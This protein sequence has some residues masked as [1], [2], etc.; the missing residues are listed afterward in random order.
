MK[1]KYILLL[2]AMMTAI[3]RPHRHGLHPNPK[4]VQA[5][6][7]GGWDL[8]LTTRDWNGTLASM[9]V[10]ALGQWKSHRSMV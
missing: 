1:T 8:P 6:D 7:G 9:P 4:H 5:P 2:I 10:W 3:G